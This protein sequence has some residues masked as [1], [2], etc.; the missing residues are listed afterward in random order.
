MEELEKAEQSALKKFDPSFQYYTYERKGQIKK[1]GIVVSWEKK[2]KYGTV[3]I[4]A[5]VSGYEMAPDFSR[6]WRDL[7]DEVKI[8]EKSE[9]TCGSTYASMLYIPKDKVDYVIHKILY[10]LLD[11]NKGYLK[12]IENWEKIT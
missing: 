5:Y 10:E 9:A 3:E 8:F 1:N 12:K 4:D 7:F 11:P 2:R 6:I